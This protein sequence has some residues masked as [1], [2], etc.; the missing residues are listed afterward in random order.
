ML[1]GINYYNSDA[2]LAGWNTNFNAINLEHHLPK[3][4]AHCI[5]H[6]LNSYLVQSQ[7]DHPS[8]LHLQCCWIRFWIHLRHFCQTNLNSLSRLLPLLLFLPLRY[9]QFLLDQIWDLH[10]LCQDSWLR[11]HTLLAI[12]AVWRFLIGFKMIKLGDLCL[13]SNGCSSVARKF[14]KMQLI[15]RQVPRAIACII[16]ISGDKTG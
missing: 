1:T 9:L 6:Y 4:F 5:L 3:I 12:Q 2:L 13:I 11:K 14:C 15:C 7:P 16:G 10:F 8:Y